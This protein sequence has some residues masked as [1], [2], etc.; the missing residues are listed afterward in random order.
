MTTYVYKINKPDYKGEEETVGEE[1]FTLGEATFSVDKP[2]LNQFVPEYLDRFVDGV[3]TNDDLVVPY[4]LSAQERAI[5]VAEAGTIVLADAPNTLT[6]MA[7]VAVNTTG[8]GLIA[9]PVYKADGTKAAITA[10]E[11][12]INTE[13]A[14]ATQEVLIAGVGTMTFTHG[15]LTGFVPV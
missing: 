12:K 1:T 10:T 14:V 9:T 15:L 6:A 13:T 3:K 7:V 5:L 11:L 8:D 4:T 2:K